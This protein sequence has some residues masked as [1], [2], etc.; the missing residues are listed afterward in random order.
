MALVECKNCGAKIS[1][2][3]TI[4]PKCGTLKNII[5]STL[6]LDS[7]DQLYKICTWVF[8]LICVVV[9]LSRTIYLLNEPSLYLVYEPIIISIIVILGNLMLYVLAFVL[10]FKK[11]NAV[12]KKIAVSTLSLTI[13]CMVFSMLS[14]E[15]LAFISHLVQVVMSIISF[16]I[17]AIKC[18]G[19]A[20]KVAWIVQ[21]ASIVVVPILGLCIVSNG[22][23]LELYIYISTP[24]ISFITAIFF[25][26]STKQNYEKE[27]EE[28]D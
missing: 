6:A 8:L 20:M 27:V 23:Q 24:I 11:L 5:P 28:L 4:C 19:W 14:S 16:A 15:M 9:I 1:D 22:E 25:V 12:P 2:K 7:K 17:L 10:A 18:K 13:V 26:L 21:I 3:A